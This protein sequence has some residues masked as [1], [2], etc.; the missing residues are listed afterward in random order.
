MEII[1]D[2]LSVYTR[3]HISVLAITRERSQKRYVM[4]CIGFMTKRCDLY[5]IQ[6]FFKGILIGFNLTAALSLLETSSLG[7][8]YLASGVLLYQNIVLFFSCF[9]Q[10]SP[11]N[12]RFD[13]DSSADSISNSNSNHLSNKFSLQLSILLT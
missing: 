6:I 13:L 7:Y 2:R 8:F 9:S 1:S 12:L 10:L 5:E 4:Y 11:L 3:R